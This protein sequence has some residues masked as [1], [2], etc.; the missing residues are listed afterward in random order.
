[1][2]CT[3][4]VEKRVENSRVTCYTLKSIAQLD[5]TTYTQP[6]LLA[7][8]IETY[9]PNKQMSDPAQHP[10]IQLSLYGAGFEKV[11]TWK[12]VNGYGPS[13]EVVENEEELLKKFAQY[14]NV[15]QPDILTGYFSDGFDFP[16]ILKRAQKHKIKLDI[17]LD[18][19]SPRFGR[20]NQS[21]VEMTGII[22]LDILNFI[23]RVTRMNL[24]TDS[25]K[26]DAVAQELLGEKKNEIDIEN[27][28]EYWDNSD[29]KLAEFAKY[30]LKD[31]QLTYEITQMLMPNIV[32]FV[33]LI[34]LPIADIV[35]MRFAQFV[36]W[37]LIKRAQEVNMLIPNKPGRTTLYERQGQHVEGAFV[38]EPKPG[39][40]DDVVVFDFRSLYPSIIVAH[41]IS[42][43]T[44]NAPSEHK[45]IVPGHP[46]M[47]FATDRDGFFSTILEEIMNRRGRIKAMM[48]TADEKKK[49]L[50]DARQY[51]LKILLNSFYG[52]LGFFGARW[53]SKECAAAVTAYGRYHIHQVINKAEAE[54]FKV[55]YS[56]TDSIFITLD[57]RTYEEAMDFVDRINA[58]LPEMMELEPE[59]FYKTALFVSAR[60]EEGGA[61]KRYALCDEQGN[62]IIKGFEAVRRNTSYI[63]KEVQTQVIKTLLRTKNTQ[64][65]TS[66]LKEVIKNLREKKIPNEKLVIVTQLTKPIEDYASIGPHVAVARQMRQRGERVEPGS[67]I[68][69]IVRPGKGKISDRVSVPELT[70]EGDYDAEYYID[71]QVIPAVERI[72]EVFNIDVKQL[73]DKRNQSSLQSFF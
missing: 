2:L 16:Y 33:K 36:E 38:Y 58:E 26:L 12:D 3:A 69:Y 24:K 50:L 71:N 19:T 66:Y 41:N 53:Y 64:E 13:V 63:A 61:K 37:Y 51:S 1:T 34:S 49:K 59:G 21:S 52:Y 8:D 42:P 72:F 5:D 54:G 20:G 4:E 45:E 17:N 65:A 32:E 68:R 15:K 60:G 22:H 46:D 6:T 73:A 39:I 55:I 48:K 28:A 43:E 56:D 31:S 44:L 18:Y 70:P 30:C 9:N 29:P 57:G 14:V 7:F 10:I 35:K 25:L 23:R 62:V 11:I 27:L 67:F 47:W 40:Y